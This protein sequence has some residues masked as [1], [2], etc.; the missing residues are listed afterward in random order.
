M[1]HHV[2]VR[3]SLVLGAA[4]AVALGALGTVPVGAADPGLTARDGATTLG[5]TGVAVVC[6]TAVPAAVVLSPEGTGG[7]TYTAAAR[8]VVTSFSHLANNVNGQVRAIVFADGASQGLKTVVAAS[9]KQTVTRSQLNTFAVRLPMAPGQRLGLGFT[10]S[11]MACATTGVAGDETQIAR[12][13]DPDTSASFVSAGTLSSSPPGSYRPNIS[14]VLEPDADGDG[15]GDVSQDACPRSAL[16]QVACPDPET[17]ITKRP[18]R[19]RDNPKVKI[20]FASTI[21]G[22]GFQCSTDGRKFRR[23]SSP[24][25]KKLGVGT[26][27]IRIRA[28]SPAGIK[29]PKPSKVRVTIGR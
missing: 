8:G 2:R 11:G 27:V 9:P 22:S 23:C 1:R 10:A 6:S 15:F 7:S 14:A 26:H 5:Q 29:D 21:P 17:S 13:F 28:I 18:K 12:P 3:P 24:F 19:F 4:V 20:T 25:K 16:S